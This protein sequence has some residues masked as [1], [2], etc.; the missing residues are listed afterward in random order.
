MVVRLIKRLGRLIRLSRSV[1]R[2][3]V[4]IKDVYDIL[5]LLDHCLL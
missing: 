2:G 1:C 4:C 3:E 5:I